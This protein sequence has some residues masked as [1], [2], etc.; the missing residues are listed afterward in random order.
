M[1]TL[2]NNQDKT[3]ESLKKYFTDTPGTAEIE[4]LAANLDAMRDGRKKQII[5]I[6]SSVLGEGK[7]TVASLLARSIAI[8]KTETVL[9]DFDLRRPHLHH[10]FGVNSENGLVDI[11]R[12]NLPF[13]MCLKETHIPHLLLISSGILDV[14]PAEIITSDRIKPFFEFISNKFDRIIVDSPPVI[15]VSDP[16]LLSKFAHEV[17]LVI[18]A[19]ST[20]R[21]VV[22]RSLKMFNDIKVKISGIVLNNMENALPRYYDYKSYQYQYYHYQSE[23]AD[24]EKRKAGI[25]KW[26]PK[27]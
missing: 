19:G 1:E 14:S 13:S 15:H 3:I 26:W 7:S 16:L 27:R 20:P 9:I 11:L 25:L 4:R 2:P 22:K 23:G 6:T 8:H 18:K 17:I 24:S 5:L 10:I 21:Y 12:S